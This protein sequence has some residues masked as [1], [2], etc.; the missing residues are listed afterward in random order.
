LAVRTYRD[1]FIFGVDSVTWLP[2]ALRATCALSA[3]RE[4]NSGE[5][6]TWLADGRLMF[7]AEGESSRVH[8]GR[9][10]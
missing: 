4:R 10:P 2:T 6:V 8:T 1:V 7:A 5:A 9:C 3:L